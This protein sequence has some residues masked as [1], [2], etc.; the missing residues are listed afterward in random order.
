[1]R[2][3][4]CHQ[5]FEPASDIGIDGALAGKPSSHRVSVFAGASDQLPLRPSHCEKTQGQT[6]W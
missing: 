3:V 6:V 5:D 2:Q 1:M 4:G